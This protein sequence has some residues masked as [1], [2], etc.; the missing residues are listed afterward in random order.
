MADLEHK[1]PTE[2]V[3]ET[4]K[5]KP[6]NKR[7]L[8]RRTL[9]TASMALLFGL[10]ACFTFLV[11]EPVIS[12][13]LYPEAPPPVVTFPEDEEEM[14]PED[15]LAEN[16]QE[17]SSDVI[18]EYQADGVQM[19][20]DWTD[21]DDMSKSLAK[22]VGIVNRS[23]VTVT[24][25]TYNVNLFQDIQTYQNQS[26]GMVITENGVEL[27][28]LADYEQIKDAQKIMVTFH[29]YLEMEA[30]LRQYDTATNIAILAV[31][32]SALPEQSREELSIVSF[33]SSKRDDLVGMP[34]VAIGN[35][36][37]TGV[38]V[39]YGY[40]TNDGTPLKLIDRNYKLLLTD[41]QGSPEGSGVLFDLE[42]K[43]VGL[44]TNQHKIP[45]MENMIT[46]IGI[47]EVKGV[48]EKMSN[49]KRIPYM[50]I[51][52]VDVPRES[53]KSLGLPEGVYVTDIAMDSP[54]MRAGVNQGDV[55]VRINAKAVRDVEDFNE[56][57][58]NLSP[59]MEIEMAVRRQSQGEYKIKTFEI[60]LGEA[61]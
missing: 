59:E 60:V 13:W 25:V 4:I 21:Y 28:I 51:G 49:G 6:V 22:Y 9:I 31:S 1:E 18:T 7:K 34:V 32:L 8:L 16:M 45:H 17:P 24:S 42:G 30:V 48:I 50:G 5:V 15:M 20:L 56:A 46:A 23:M 35:P 40:I 47:T 33:G 27:L 19:R 2:Y 12:N 57:L 39:G 38:S 41:I 36:M 54:A 43:V 29:N 10:I 61:K 44:I 14:E 11:L 37:G 52:C 26:S 58:M 55:I 3:K 53:Q